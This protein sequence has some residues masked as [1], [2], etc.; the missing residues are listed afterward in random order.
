M[1]R[2]P[3]NAFFTAAVPETTPWASLA[4]V[5][6]LWGDLLQGIRPVHPP[7]VMRHTLDWLPEK[8][9]GDIH[10]LL[11]SLGVP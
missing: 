10:R 4:G 5:L 8:E 7:F 9:V 1:G 3:P 6:A 11:P 2:T